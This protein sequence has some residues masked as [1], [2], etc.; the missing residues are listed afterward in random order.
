MMFACFTLDTRSAPSLLCDSIAK[1]CKLRGKRC[2]WGWDLPWVVNLSITQRRTRLATPIPQL[3]S[4]HG[5][6]TGYTLRLVRIPSTSFRMPSFLLSTSCPSCQSEICPSLH[7]PSLRQ[8]RILEEAGQMPLAYIAA[9]T[10]GLVQEAER[11]ASGLSHTPEQ[12]TTSTPPQLL[13]PP[14]PILKVRGLA[15][16]HIIPMGM[17]IIVS[18][19][20]VE[21]L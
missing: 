15:R 5:S 12:P 3:L 14:T 8:V 18:I 10:H 20:P 4:F 13:L 7:V 9:N 16:S 21:C 11:I 6:Y 1:G 17:L 19:P 2:A